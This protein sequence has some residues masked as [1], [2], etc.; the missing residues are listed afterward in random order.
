MVASRVLRLLGMAGVLLF[1]LCAYTPLP[2]LLSH[3]TEIPAP[4]EPAEAIVVLAGSV[5]VRGCA[6]PVAWTL[7]PAG[8]KRAWRPAW[9]RLLRLLRPAIPADWTVLVLADRGLYARW[10]F[11]RIVRLGGPPFRRINL[12]GKCRPAGLAAFRPLASFV[13]VPGGRWRAAGTAFAS[14][15]CR[16]GRT[17]AA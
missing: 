6:L 9:L 13:P 15:A 1:V 3:R 5:V 16:L 8:D 12:G 10:P 11:R 7:L 14:K 4:L 2:N 17:L